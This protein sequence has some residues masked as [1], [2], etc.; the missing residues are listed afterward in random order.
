MDDRAAEIEK[1]QYVI[2]II[3]LYSQKGER[4]A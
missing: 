2:Q 4:T 1:Q 3:Q